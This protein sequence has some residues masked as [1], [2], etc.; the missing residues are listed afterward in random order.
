MTAVYQETRKVLYWLYW[1]ST[2][3]TV[4]SFLLCDGTYGAVKCLCPVQVLSL[5][6]G[7]LGHATPEGIA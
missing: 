2:C 4:A 3:E 1:F 5:P 7:V 6:S